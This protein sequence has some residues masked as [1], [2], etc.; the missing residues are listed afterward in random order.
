LIDTD[1]RVW[2]RTKIFERGLIVGDVE[3]PLFDSP[4]TFYARHGD[5]F[6]YLCTA[7]T[8]LASAFAFFRGRKQS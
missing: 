5:V 4:G 3:L 6:A 1:G 2:S 8:V 7:A